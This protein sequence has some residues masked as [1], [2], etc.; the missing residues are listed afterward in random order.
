MLKESLQEVVGQKAES[1]LEGGKH[2]SLVCVRC[3]DV[4]SSS[5]LPLEHGVIW[6]KAICNKFVNFSF[7]RNG[8][9]KKVWVRGGHGGRRKVYGKG[10]ELCSTLLI[11]EGQIAHR[12]WR[13]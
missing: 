3:W 1:V 9:L 8:L 7:I 6:E 10:L 5:R 2:H 4:F 12:R 13:A 11:E